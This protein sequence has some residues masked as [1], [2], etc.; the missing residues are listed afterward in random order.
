MAIA[1]FFMLAEAI[2]VNKCGRNLRGL[3]KCCSVRSFDGFCRNGKQL[4][5]RP[6]SLP[7]E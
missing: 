3:R 6:M 5:G 7:I 2:C 1:G 4:E